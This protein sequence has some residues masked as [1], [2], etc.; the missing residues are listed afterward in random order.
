[1][2]IW[3]RLGLAAFRLSGFDFAERALR[4][5]ESQSHWMDVYGVGVRGEEHRRSETRLSLLNA[6]L[7]TR[8][9][10]RHEKRGARTPRMNL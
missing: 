8:S 3:L 10:H 2:R 4:N 1:M 9:A 7:R 5:I 6:K